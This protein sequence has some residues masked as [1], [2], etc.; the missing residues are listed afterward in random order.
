MDESGDLGFSFDRGSTEYF[1]ITFLFAPSKRRL[2]KIAKEIH[3]G[4]RKKHKLMGAL[5]A[6]NEKPATRRRLLE[7][8][9]TAD[10][11]IMAIVLNKRRVYTRL[12][13]E[14]AVLY[15][16][17]ANILLDRLL[18][19]KILPTEDDIVLI[20]SKRETNRFLNENFKDY[21]ARQVRSKFRM[22]VKIATP[23]Q[24]KALQIA[25]FVSWAIFR[26]HEHADSSYRDIVSGLIVEESPLFP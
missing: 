22:V 24:E 17:V 3:G 16:Y 8:L 2:E 19:K 21:L 26:K 13:D 20:A 4:L 5:H 18:A 12:Q 14:K 7:K 9:A 25:D 23:D 11:R 10:V 1:I 15:N 6:H